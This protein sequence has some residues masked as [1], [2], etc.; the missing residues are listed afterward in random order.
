MHRLNQRQSKKLG[1]KFLYLPDQT[2][3]LSLHP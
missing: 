3:H 2:A 1:I